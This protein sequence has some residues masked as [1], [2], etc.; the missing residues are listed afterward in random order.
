MNC[1]RNI[2]IVGVS[3][4]LQA[5]EITE[6]LGRKLLGRVVH[7]LEDTLPKHPI[8]YMLRMDDFRVSACGAFRFREHFFFNGRMAVTKQVCA[9]PN[10]R[11]T[12][13][14]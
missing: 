8:N 5:H 1:V 4:T 3:C 13:M 14:D 12:I 6:S 10:A 2:T 9:G 11:I 7:I